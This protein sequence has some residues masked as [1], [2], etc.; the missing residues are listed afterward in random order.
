MMII[1]VCIWNCLVDG[2]VCKIILDQK[3]YQYKFD[4]M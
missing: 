1:D 4:I 3:V 2:Y